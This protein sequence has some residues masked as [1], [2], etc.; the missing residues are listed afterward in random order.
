MSVANSPRFAVLMG[1]VCV[2]EN[3]DKTKMV[4]DRLAYISNALSLV[5]AVTVG[6]KKRRGK[7]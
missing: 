2:R 1:C 6:E 7:L 4:R 3:E 5:V